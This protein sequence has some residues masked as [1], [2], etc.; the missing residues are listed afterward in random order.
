[1]NQGTINFAGTVFV[2]VG[3]VLSSLYL[4]SGMGLA[5]P[6]IGML[7]F[8]TTMAAGSAFCVGQHDG[9]LRIQ[10][11]HAHRQARVKSRVRHH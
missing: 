2:I 4:K 11:S 7:T 1:M 8:G 9:D 3:L 6:L 5:T 10:L